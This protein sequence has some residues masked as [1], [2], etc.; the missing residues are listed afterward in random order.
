M[1]K[2]IENLVKSIIANADLDIKLGN[3][4]EGKGTKSNLL[5]ALKEIG[6][7]KEEIAQMF[8]V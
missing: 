4:K 1:E 7:S 2:N 6:Y 8:G 3:E 5:S